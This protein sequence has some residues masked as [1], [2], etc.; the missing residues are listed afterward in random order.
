MTVLVA[1]RMTLVSVQGKPEKR[2]VFHSDYGLQDSRAKW[3][4]W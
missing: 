4:A 2:E 1:T 3:L